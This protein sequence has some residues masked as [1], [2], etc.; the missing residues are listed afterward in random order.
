MNLG[1]LKDGKASIFILE[2]QKASKSSFAES[3]CHDSLMRWLPHCRSSHLKL[4]DWLCSGYAS[5][6]GIR[7]TRNSLRHQWATWKNPIFKHHVGSTSINISHCIYHT[8]YPQCSAHCR[9]AKHTHHPSHVYI[10]IITMRVHFACSAY[11]ASA[12]QK[13]HTL[14]AQTQSDTQW[15]PGLHKNHTVI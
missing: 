13:W 14:S 15:Y 3:L 6:H 5:R 4:T 7:W 2:E 12:Y 9:Q 10:L 11:Q 8:F 1:R